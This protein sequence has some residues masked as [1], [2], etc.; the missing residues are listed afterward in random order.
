MGFSRSRPAFLTSLL[1]LLLFLFLSLLLSSSLSLPLPA[2]VGTAASPGLVHGR[3]G[4]SQV[5]HVMKPRPWP[6]LSGVHYDERHPTAMQNR[7]R[8]RARRRKK[9]KGHVV[10]DLG[11]RSFSAMMPRGFVPPSDSSW[12][13]NEAPRAVGFFCEDKSISRP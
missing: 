4:G 6:S 8:R 5:I 12:C 11:A 10:Y 9:K 1:L 7:K 3:R 2:Q 13:H